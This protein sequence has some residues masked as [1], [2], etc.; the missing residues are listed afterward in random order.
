[1]FCRS[2]LRPG[3]PSDKNGGPVF[4]GK[5]CVEDAG[6]LLLDGNMAISGHAS[7]NAAG[8]N[9]RAQK[10]KGVVK[11]LDREFCRFLAGIKRGP[12]LGAPEGLMCK[13]TNK[14]WKDF[15]AGR[16]FPI[17]A[18]TGSWRF[19]SKGRGLEFRRALQPRVEKPLRCRRLMG[20]RG[21]AAQGRACGGPCVEA[22]CLD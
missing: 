22:P 21:K 20:R 9:S 2:R 13:T 8:E 1:M 12:W 18:G 14:N 3:I 17:S 7:S 19:F 4:P 11:K 10:P 5:I 15:C 6:A 16:G